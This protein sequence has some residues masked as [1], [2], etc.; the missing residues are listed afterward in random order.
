LTLA[1]Q[2][3]FNVGDFSSSEP[4]M[5]GMLSPSRKNSSVVARYRAAALA[6]VGVVLVTG[7]S[8]V[9]HAR[10]WTLD[11]VERN[12]TADYPSVAQLQPAQFAKLMQDPSKV[13]VFDVREQAEFDVSHL[14][15]AIRVSPSIWTSQ[16]MSR[17][18]EAAKGRTAVFYCSVGVRSSKLARQ[19]GDRLKAGGAE[20]V[21]NLQGGIFRWHNEARP[22]VANSGPTKQVHPYDAHW[23]QLLT[24]P[25]SPDKSS[26]ARQ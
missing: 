14:P 2:P 21:Y 26:P 10:D 11:I 12:V 23:G 8:P 18:G 20:A 3:V 6:L 9:A 7:L 13:V 4:A 5:I 1:L 24:T 25:A 16:F 19:V 17:F 15:G 22:M